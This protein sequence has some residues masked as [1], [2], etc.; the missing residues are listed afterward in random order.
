MESW[1]VVKG[2]KSSDTLKDLKHTLVPGTLKEGYIPG[3]L[4]GKESAC[5]CRRCERH[6]FDP[7]VGKIGRLES[8]GSQKNWTQLSN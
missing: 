8:L 6:R 2:N 1:G 3:W 5:Q 4:G 7:W